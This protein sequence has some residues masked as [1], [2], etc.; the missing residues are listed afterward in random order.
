MIYTKVFFNLSKTG[1]FSYKVTYMNYKYENTSVT[2]IPGTVLPAGANYQFSIVR[3]WGREGGGKE[4]GK[5]GKGYLAPPLDITSFYFF[6]LA[7]LSLQ[8]L[9][10]SIQCI[11]I[12]QT[13]KI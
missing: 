11:S 4:K 2:S 1:N 13:S 6:I 3:W 8:H 10:F 12:F 7:V 9:Q 5:K